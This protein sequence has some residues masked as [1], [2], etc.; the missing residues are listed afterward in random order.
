MSFLDYMKGF[1]ILHLS[2]VVVAAPLFLMVIL[3][4]DEIQRQ[5]PY[6]Q[7][8]SELS[9]QCFHKAAGEDGILQDEEKTRLIK[10]LGY[11]GA[12][13][14]NERV[15]AV[16]SVDGLRF[17][18]GAASDNRMYGMYMSLIPGQQPLVKVRDTF[19]A[20]PEAMEKYLIKKSDLTNKV[21]LK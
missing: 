8:V 9:N 10:D 12:I 5:Q 14:E 19:L 3:K 16:Y 1:G 21:F 2:C 17:G 11:S 13:L 7:R 6:I 20:T 15:C 4:N 18:M